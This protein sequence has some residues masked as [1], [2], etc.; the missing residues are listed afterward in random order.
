MEAVTAMSQDKVPGGELQLEGPP[1]TLTDQ[2]NL[3]KLKG[4]NSCFDDGNSS[5]RLT[6]CH[7]RCRTTPPRVCSWDMSPSSF[8][9][10]LPLQRNPGR[11]REEFEQRNRGGRARGSKGRGKAAADES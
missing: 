7:H 9:I 1:T 4:G 6:G 11:R 5:R 2:L 8:V 3:P 10:K